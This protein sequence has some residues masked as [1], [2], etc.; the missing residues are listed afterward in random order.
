MAQSNRPPIHDWYPYFD[1]DMN[2]V[3]LYGWDIV[4]RHIFTVLVT[5]IGTRQWQPKFGCKLLD[6]LF[7]AEAS[8]DDI[9]GD[10]K[11]A[12][13][14][15]PHIDLVSTT[16]KMEPMPDG[17]GRRAA[18]QLRVNYEGEEK[19]VNFIIPAYMDLLNGTIHK[20][21]VIRNA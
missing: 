14:W 8:E 5:R 7:D 4:L 9:I 19:D 12:F 21:Q 3:E 16:C 20:I 17:K 15:L 6:R 1:K 10:I 13:S 11:T 18:I 2:F